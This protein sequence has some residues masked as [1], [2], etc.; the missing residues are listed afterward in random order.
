MNTIEEKCD[1]C[2]GKLIH[3]CSLCKGTGRRIEKINLTSD[4][5]MEN[6]SLCPL[7]HGTV[8]IEDHCDFKE[9][10]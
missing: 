4:W 5:N 10:D 1:K 6:I 9:K 8:K 3:V 7:C 2:D